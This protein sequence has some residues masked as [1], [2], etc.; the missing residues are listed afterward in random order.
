GTWPLDYLLRDQ[1]P[2]WSEL[3]G[4]LGRDWLIE[5][6]KGEWIWGGGF[7]IRLLFDFCCAIH[8]HFR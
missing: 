1:P 3:P 7:G 2:A 4:L 8:D 6:V 5:G